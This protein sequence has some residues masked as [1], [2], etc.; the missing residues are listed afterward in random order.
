MRRSEAVFKKTGLEVI[1]VGSDFTGISAVESD[2]RIYN[3]IPGPGGFTALGYYL[4]EQIGWLYY[5][6]RGWL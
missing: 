3:I 4:H 2:S 6:M 1:P 5:R